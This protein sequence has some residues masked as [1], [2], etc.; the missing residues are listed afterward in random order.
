MRRFLLFWLFA[1]LSLVNIYGMQGSADLPHFFPKGVIQTTDPATQWEM[2]LRYILATD[3]CQGILGEKSKF[4]TNNISSVRET[5]KMFGKD[6]LLVL[7]PYARNKERDGVITFTS[8]CGQEVVTEAQLKVIRD[9]MIKEQ[10][11]ATELNWTLYNDVRELSVKERARKLGVKEEEFRARLDKPSYYKGISVREEHLLPPPFEKSDFV[12]R[13]L[14]LGYFPELAGQGILG[15]VWL[16]SGVSYITMQALILDYLIGQPTVLAHETVHANKKLQSL[17]L[18]EGFNVELFASIPSLL[19]EE[20]KQRLWFH[21]Y[22]DLLR[23]IMWVHFGFDFKQA[24]K[25]IIKVDLL[26]N[27][28][29]DRDKFNKYTAMLDKAKP[30]LLATM[31]KAFIEFYSDAPGWVAFNDKLQNDAAVVDFIFARSFD[32][33]VQVT[34]KPGCAETMKWLKAREEEIKEMAKKAF[35]KSGTAATTSPDVEEAIKAI[36]SGPALKTLRSALPQ[37]EEKEIMAFLV[38]EG[39]TVNDLVKMDGIKLSLLLKKFLAE[40]ENRR[41]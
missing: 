29:I 26:G 11:R 25:E 23:E 10:T 27:L 38:K 3:H 21:S 18:S 41:R 19:L 28:H 6:M 35:E 30:A 1:G 5:V 31:K 34:E 2:Y 13:E 16:N 15:A 33:C 17:P 40:Q 32:F 37:L 14:H 8:Y 24:R 12:P 39:L 36:P 22:V 7:D 9:Y 4:I 20:D